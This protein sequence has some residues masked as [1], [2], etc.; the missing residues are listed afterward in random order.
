[1]IRFEGE[2]KEILHFRFCK[3]VKEEECSSSV[4]F[5]AL[6]EDKKISKIN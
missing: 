3:V 1:M 2:N 5:P 4:S 6:M